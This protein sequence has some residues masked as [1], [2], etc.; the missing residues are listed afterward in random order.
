MVVLFESQEF[1]HVRSDNYHSFQNDYFMNK[2][3]YGGK[4]LVTD[5]NNLAYRQGKNTLARTKH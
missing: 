4:I 1:D 5:C 2:I 3:D